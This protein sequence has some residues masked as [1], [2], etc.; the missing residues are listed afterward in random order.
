VVAD[1]ECVDKLACN[2]VAI[3]LVES[4]FVFGRLELMI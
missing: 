3:V 2:V 1:P 4:G